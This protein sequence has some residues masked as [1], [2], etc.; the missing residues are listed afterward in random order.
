MSPILESTDGF[1]IVR[2]LER[3]E[4]SRRPFTDVQIEI[5]ETLKKQRFNEG[6]EK[7]LAKL[8]QDARI[9]TVFTGNVSADVLMGR[10]PGDTQQR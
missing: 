9:W 5:R 10:K 3:K 4:A 6:V 8:R 2:V 1:H 7:Y